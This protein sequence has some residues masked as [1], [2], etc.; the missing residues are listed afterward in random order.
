VE[1]RGEREVS[2]EG[3]SEKGEKGKGED[4]ICDQR[5]KKR[6]ARQ[7]EGVRFAA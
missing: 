3:K 6:E 7:V 4:W 5:K 2:G 1:G